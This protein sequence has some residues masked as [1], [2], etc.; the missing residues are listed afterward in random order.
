MKRV[1]T[2]NSKKKTIRGVHRVTKKGLNRK[3]EEKNQKRSK[4]VLTRYE[5][6][7]RARASR[8]AKDPLLCNARVNNKLIIPRRAR[9]GL[10]SSLSHYAYRNCSSKTIYGSPV[11]NVVRSP[12]LFFLIILTV[13]ES[14]TQFSI[15][16]V[17]K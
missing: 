13:Y 14:Y 2:G 8:R 6:N 4:C 16:L 7:M 9:S 1:A 3:K 15:G 11:R 12:V 5:F 17:S 10:A